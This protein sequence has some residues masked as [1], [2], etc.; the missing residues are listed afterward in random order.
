M[1]STVNLPESEQPLEQGSAGYVLLA[2]SI[3][4]CIYWFFHSWHYWE[5]DA[6]I[7]LEFA[8]SVAAGKG[9][10]FNGRIVAGDTAPLWVLLLATTHVFIANWIVTGKVLTI[11]GAI[12]G[13]AG[14]YAFARRL[15]IQ[16]LPEAQIFPAAIILLIAVNPYTCYWI[17]SGMETIAAAGL[18]CFAVLAATRARPTTTSFFA[19][20]LLAGIAPLVRP[21][22]LF[23]AALLVLPLWGQYRSLRTKGPSAHVFGLILLVTPLTLWSIYSLHAFGH[24]LPNTNA[25]KRAGPD[26][27]V[28]ARLI[29]VYS[30]GLPVIVFGILAAISSLVLRA[31]AVRNSLRAAVASAV[32]PPQGSAAKPL[33][34]LP[35]SAW[36]FIMWAMIATFFYIANHTYVQTRYIFVPAPALTI[37]VLLQFARFSRTVARTVYTLGLTAAIGVTAIVVYPFIHNK[38]IVCDDTT[39]FALYLRNH[40]PPDAPVAIYSIGQVAFVSQ[41]PI[42]DTGGITQPE[43][44]PYLKA[45]P[46]ATVQWAA[47]VGAQYYVDSHSPVQGATAVYSTEF[48]FI[49]WSFHVSRYA[50]TD[51][52]ILWKLPVAPAPNPFLATSPANH[53]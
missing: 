42:V 20:C 52:F 22:M 32:N 37:I 18:A 11:L 23:L 14:I 7:H 2:I 26:Q 27:S 13:F 41:H 33:K 12:F 31:S 44:I 40:I 25:A 17:F 24:I 30:I 28:V 16:F 35:L 3:A 4:W 48:P 36:I 29:S 34:T 1:P 10:A 46:N 21:E 6:W 39:A 45:H 19:A 9:F 50:T 8:R 38:G 47:S 51:P 15:S 53:P 49:G 5:D 43:S